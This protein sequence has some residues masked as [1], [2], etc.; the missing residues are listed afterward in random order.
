MVSTT[1]TAPEHLVC[2]QMLTSTY[3]LYDQM[4][5]KY[6]GSMTYSDQQMLSSLSTILY[7]T[8][9][10]GMDTHSHTVHHT[11]YHG[12]TE[13]TIML[14]LMV[15]WTEQALWDCVSGTPQQVYQEQSY[16]LI[17]EH[18]DMTYSDQQMLSILTCTPDCM[19]HYEVHQDTHSQQQYYTPY[20][21]TQVP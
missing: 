3:V 19:V 4:F 2:T 6:L 10:Y 7:G 16:V 1:L 15:Q 21:Y 14:V 12:T 17:L 13:S 5:T 11:R 8:L 18:H 20:E 9:W